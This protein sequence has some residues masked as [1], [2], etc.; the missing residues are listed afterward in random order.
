MRRTRGG[1]SSATCTSARGCACVSVSTERVWSSDCLIAASGSAFDAF[2]ICY[3][4]GPGCSNGSGGRASARSARFGASLRA[5]STTAVD[6]RSG[7]RRPGSTSGS[8][9]ARRAFGSYSISESRGG[10]VCLTGSLHGGAGSFN[11]SLRGD[12]S[13]SAALTLRY[14]P[15]FDYSKTR[16]ASSF[17]ART[18]SSAN[19]FGALTRALTSAF[20]YLTSGGGAFSTGLRRAF[21]SPSTASTLCYA[22]ARPA[23]GYVSARPFN[24]GATSCAFRRGPSDFSRTASDGRRGYS[25]G[26]GAS[27]SAASTS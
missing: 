15:D 12:G 22:G 19:S 18:R 10:G 9:G 5:S 23:S 11:G 14:G 24:S 27:G 3:G 13:R 20:D 6:S 25:T 7:L 8:A 16:S 26:S 4:G 21:A 1:S 2:A 17:A